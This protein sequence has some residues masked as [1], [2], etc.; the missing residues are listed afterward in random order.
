[1]Y[2]DITNPALPMVIIEDQSQDH[3]GFSEY[4]TISSRLV[5]WVSDTTSLVYDKNWEGK[6]LCR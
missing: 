2:P 4:P 3:D 5:S 1:M 6:C